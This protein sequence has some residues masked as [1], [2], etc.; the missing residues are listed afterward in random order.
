MQYFSFDPTVI[1]RISIVS[2]RKALRYQGDVTVEGVG[3][4]AT[5]GLVVQRSIHG[6]P[7]ENQGQFA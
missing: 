7:Q 4:A 5:A 3:Y 1:R 6:S 2:V